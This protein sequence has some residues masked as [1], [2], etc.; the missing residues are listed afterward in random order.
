MS[1]QATAFNVG[2]KVFLLMNSGQV[3]TKRLEIVKVWRYPTTY[4]YQLDTGYVADHAEL[5]ATDDAEPPT[6]EPAAAAAPSD[7]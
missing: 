4:R 1:T 2:Q 3:T 7:E 6:A 5:R